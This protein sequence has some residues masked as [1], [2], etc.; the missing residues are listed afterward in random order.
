MKYVEQYDCELKKLYDEHQ[1]SAS[2]ILSSRKYKYLHDYVMSCTCMFSNINLAT[3]AWHTIYHNTMQ[4][5]CL[6]CGKELTNANI[7]FKNVQ[8]FRDAFVKYCC[9]K[10]GQLN[11]IT[12]KKIKQ[13]NMQKYGVEWSFQSENN[14]CKSKQTMLQ[15]YGVQYAQQCRKLK[16]KSYTSM[17]QK[18]GVKYPMQCNEIKALARISTRKRQYKKFA[19]NKYIEPLFTEEEY[20]ENGDSAQYTWKC[21]KCGSMF[22]SS[23]NEVWYK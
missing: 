6:T 12:K 16:D 13:T 11:D 20:V 18:Y 15:K 14:K 21:K 4:I 22:Q 5:H 9:P 1:Q 7:K 3:R 2:R 19:D 23:R 10:C 8:E 17:I